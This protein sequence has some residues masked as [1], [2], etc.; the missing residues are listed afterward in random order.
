M[1]SSA[2]SQ[3]AA[4]DGFEDRQGIGPPAA[5]AGYRASPLTEWRPEK[6][7]KQI[8]QIIQNIFTNA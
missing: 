3:T 2:R 4:T 6:K 7:K 8:R 1:L 5:W